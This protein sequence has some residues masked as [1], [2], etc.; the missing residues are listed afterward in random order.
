MVSS[1]SGCLHTSE[2]ITNNTKLRLVAVD[3]V[4]LIYNMSM[5]VG[6]GHY[7]LAY[8]WARGVLHKSS[9]KVTKKI[10]YMQI[11]MGNCCKNVHFLLF[12]KDYFIF[13]PSVFSFQFGGVE[14]D[15]DGAVIDE[16]DFHVGTE[17]TGF[18]M[19]SVH[20]TESV[21]KVIIQR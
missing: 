17:T 18:Y 16:I 15:G 8:E 10:P 19:E 2:L 13:Y 4:F 14:E 12:M 9:G 21:V 7:S 5:F 6:F 3:S 1:S 11:Y 20:S